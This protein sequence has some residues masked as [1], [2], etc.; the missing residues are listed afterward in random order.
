MATDD[1]RAALQ[2]VVDRL[3]LW[4]EYAELGELLTAA[5]LG[6]R[7]A[8]P[9]QNAVLST[10]ARRW[11]RQL[12]RFR[13][14]AQAAAQH[15]QRRMIF[16]PMLP[17]ERWV[18]SVAKTRLPALRA[19]RTGLQCFGLPVDD[20]NPALRTAEIRARGDTAWVDT[21]VC[22]FLLTV[23]DEVDQSAVDLLAAEAPVSGDS[24]TPTPAGRLPRAGGP[25][26]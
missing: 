7:L 16:G 2:Q 17:A 15:L 4:P 26:G 8:T 25:A 5:E 1:D 23:G 24:P 19:L 6:P 3:G 11:A 9:P 10:R 12:T 20:G 21:P 18:W 14:P 22:R 13:Q